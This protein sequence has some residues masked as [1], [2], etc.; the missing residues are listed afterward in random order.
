MSHDE[1]M[2]SSS[3]ANEGGLDSA[4]DYARAY[5]A[6]NTEGTFNLL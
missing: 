2:E 5:A 3:Y 4:E 6:A 1:A